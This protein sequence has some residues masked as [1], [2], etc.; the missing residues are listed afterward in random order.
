[1][2]LPE[3]A[4]F[5]A[6]S[7]DGFIAREDGGLDWLPQPDGGAGGGEDHGYADFMASVDALVMGRKTFETVRSFGVWPYGST[8]VV[9][10]STGGPAVPE[11]IRPSGEVGGGA[12]AGLLR[13]LGAD[14]VRR[15][16]VDGGQTIQRFLRAGLISDL[17]LTRVPVLPGSGIPLFGEVTEDVALEHVATRAFP[18]G[19]V[20]SRYRIARS[21]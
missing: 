5:I 11:A 6:T 17:V 8:R 4:V 9:V 12:P 18:N 14:G 21:S 15:V 13:R 3:A 7:L 1:M 2:P 10:L 19:L 20:Q 16:Y